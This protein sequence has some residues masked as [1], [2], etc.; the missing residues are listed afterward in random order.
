MTSPSATHVTIS[1][2]TARSNVESACL[3]D[4]PGWQLVRRLGGGGMTEVFQ[5]RPLGM[6]VSQSAGYAIKTLAE[7]SCDGTV[8]LESLCREVRA[9]HQVNSPHVVAV[10]AANLHQSPHFVVMPLL[11]GASLADL[12]TTGLRPVLPVALWI[13]RQVAEALDALQTVG[14]MHGDIK[15]G[16]VIVAPSGHVTLIDLGFARRL[17]DSNE[18]WDTSQ[19]LAG[20][21]FYLAPELL[22]SQLRSDIRSDIYSLGVM[23]YEMLAGHVPFSAR[24]PAQLVAQHR[25]ERPQDL[26]IIIP[27]LPTRVARF[28]RTMLAKDPHRRPQTPCE[29][30]ERLASL[31][32]ETFCLR[33]G[34]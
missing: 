34:P 19:L 15:P 17:D 8:A 28:V 30:A 12:L 33:T 32:V 6:P 14:W 7:N 27:H 5:A 13:A 22:T 9:A 23:L 2:R 29:V 26:R 24:D 4:I 25:E 11:A 16:N 18:S 1:A 10:L 31:E 20:T 3:P 21:L